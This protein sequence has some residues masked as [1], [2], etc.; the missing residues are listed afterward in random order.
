[1][2]ICLTNAP[3][4]LWYIVGKDVGKFTHLAQATVELVFAIGVVL[5][6]VNDIGS[7]NSGQF[8]ASTVLTGAFIGEI[9]GKTYI[10]YEKFKNP[11]AEIEKTEQLLCL[12]EA[13]T[14]VIQMVFTFADLAAG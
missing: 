6:Y 3:L 5:A 2:Q 8:I 11:N 10:N 7:M 9:F 13:G 12:A 1:M 14:E 4:W